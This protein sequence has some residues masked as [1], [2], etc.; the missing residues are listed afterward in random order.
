VNL[1]VV[2]TSDQ[3]ASATLVQKPQQ[4]KG[5]GMMAG[6]SRIGLGLALQTARPKAC[7]RR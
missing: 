6:A 1:R 7:P 3:E 2:L 4:Q 5:S